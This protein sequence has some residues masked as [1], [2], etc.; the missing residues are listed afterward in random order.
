MNDLMLAYLI[1]AI[2]MLALSLIVFGDK[3]ASR[4]TKSKS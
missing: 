4:I 3:I 1:V 2:I